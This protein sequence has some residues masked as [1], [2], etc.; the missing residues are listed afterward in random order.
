MR[1][2]PPE[3]LTPSH[4]EPISTPARAPDYAA[5]PTAR[6]VSAPP[7]ARRNIRIDKRVHQLLV[8]GGLA[9]STVLAF[10]GL[11]YP[12]WLPAAAV[13]LLMTAYGMLSLLYWMWSAIA[14]E[15]A[16]TTP[17]RAVAFMLVPLFNVYW[18][19]HVVAGYATDY[20]EYLARHMISAPRLSR[21]LLLAA[22]VV[23]IAN[24]VIGWI[25]L[26]RVIDAVNALS[27]RAPGGHGT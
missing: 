19:F 20:N 12:V 24:L 9:S 13:P 21:D 22:L 6:T 17:I 3:E 8:F 15:Q 7:V 16:R 5:L 2:E 14:G 25:A 23:P 26:E 27:P 1:D 18:A 4:P 10:A 11:F